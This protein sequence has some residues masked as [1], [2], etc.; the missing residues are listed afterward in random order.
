MMTNAVALAQQ[1]GG[2]VSRSDAGRLSACTP[3][4]KHTSSPSARLATATSLESTA[5]GGSG[6]G[7]YAGAPKNLRR[8]LRDVDGMKSDI[9]GMEAVLSAVKGNAPTLTCLYAA[10]ILAH[11]HQRKLACCD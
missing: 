6:D 7:V 1:S 9:A 11:Q 3:A 10:R 5:S 2:G 8:A 4:S